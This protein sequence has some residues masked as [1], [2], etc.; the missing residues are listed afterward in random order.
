MIIF[1]CAALLISLLGLTAMS[2]YFIA[3]RKR[4]MAVRKVFGSSS[5]GEMKRLMRFSLVSLLISLVIAIPLMIFGVRQIDKIVTFDSAFPWWVPLVS[6]A[7]V[8][9]ISLISV[10]FISLK[11]TRENPVNN[12]K[13]E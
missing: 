5:S 13:T 11:A 6:I 9:L 2:I 8:S 3:Q 1:T 7:T 10:F 4:D 12:L